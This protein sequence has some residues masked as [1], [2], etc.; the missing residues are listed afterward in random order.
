MELLVPNMIELLWLGT[1]DLKEKV[2]MIIKVVIHQNPKKK[3][4]SPTHDDLVE[5][6]LQFF[7]MA[8]KEELLAAAE[9][10]RWRELKDLVQTQQTWRIGECLLEKDRRRA[11]K[12]LRRGLMYLEDSVHSARGDH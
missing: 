4:A 8:A 3:K 6:L 2:M 5:N 12:C 11:E 9:L 10:L 1:E 7:D